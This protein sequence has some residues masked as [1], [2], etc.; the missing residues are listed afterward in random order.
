M[1]LC[2]LNGDYLPLA[3]ARVSPMDR[4]FL[5]GEGAYEVVPVYGRRPF[6]LADHLRRFRRTL[7]HLR[8]TD[9]LD[10]AGWGAVVARLVAESE[11]E[12]LQVYLHLTRGAEMARDQAFPKDA[13]P[14]VFAF[15][16]PLVTPSADLLEQGVAAYT[17]ADIRWLR[18]DLK[19]TALLANCLL[20]QQAVDRGGAETLL[21]RDGFLTE[22]CASNIFVVRHGLLLA[23]PKTHLMLSGIT[24]DVVLE[25][26]QR[27]G[28]P[29]D[30]REITEAEVRAADELWMTSSTREILPITRLDD[31]P[32]GDGRPGPLARQMFDWYQDFKRTV[33]RAGEAG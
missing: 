22:G 19:V 3:Q 25:L 4:G 24:Y 16:A 23:P 29:F 18:C 33:M 31:R 6:R 30:V 17:A 11:A 8:M 5:F 14:T 13:A 15:A 7:D 2:Y 12:D 1:T 21:F 32:V 10:E 26:A 28:V 27:N 9:P 20:R